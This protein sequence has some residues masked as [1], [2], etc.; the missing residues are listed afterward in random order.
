MKQDTR[1]KG[2][3]RPTA[4]EGCADL[5]CRGSKIPEQKVVKDPQLKRGARN[6]EDGEHLGE[7]GSGP[8]PASNLILVQS[9]GGSI[10][11]E[12]GLG[13]SRRP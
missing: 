8:R 10:N 11:L 5:R 13:G 2:G 7:E 1:A 12:R 3:E 6:R 9:E 4:Q